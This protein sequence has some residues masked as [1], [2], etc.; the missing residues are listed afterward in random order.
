MSAFSVLAFGHADTLEAPACQLQRFALFWLLISE[1][2]FDAVSALAAE[3]FRDGEGE[4]LVADDHIS[5]FFFR[6]WKLDF[7]NLQPRDPSALELL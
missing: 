1:L 2:D 5:I 6:G 4:D 7:L 3:L